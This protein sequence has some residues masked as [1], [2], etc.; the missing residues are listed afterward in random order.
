MELRVL[1]YFLTAAR[2]ENITKAAAL[3][4]VSQ[5]SLSRQLM[6]LEK[7]LGVKL[8]RRSNHSIILTEEGIWLKRRAQ[9]M[10]TL[11][12]MTKR[13]LAKMEDISGVI[14]IG[15]GE[16]QSSALLAELM[17]AFRREHP[18]VRYDFYSG[19]S[20]NIK[21]RLERGILD[22]GLLLEPVELMKYQFVR[23]PVKESWG[24]LVREDSPLAQKNA[25]TPA[26]LAGM[27][28]IITSRGMIRTELAGW[29]GCYAT[30]ID[31]VAGGNLPYN[32]AALAAKDAGVYVNLK[33]NCKYDGLKFVP[34]SP[35]L[36]LGTVLAWKRAQP[37]TR[38]VEAFLAFVQ[39]C[40]LDI[41]EHT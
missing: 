8:F 4:H 13:E 18:M 28:V 23:L 24:A 25:I 20:D 30:Q 9:E 1:E 40:I 35:R 11:A 31:Y 12:D 37:C 15:S 6:Q 26:D 33:L 7:E 16:Y 41:S 21:E 10:L 3:L 17:V 34:L 38:A 27:P 32:L 39:K 2:E 14:S 29:L 5:P 22:F 19:N 36:E